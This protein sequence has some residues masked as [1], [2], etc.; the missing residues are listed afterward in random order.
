MISHAE[1]FDF[2]LNFLI[3][4]FFRYLNGNER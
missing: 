3:I 4:I 1:S 2:Q